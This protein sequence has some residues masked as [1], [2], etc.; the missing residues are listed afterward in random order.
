MLFFKW[1]KGYV[2][3]NIPL[4]VVV[5]LSISNITQTDCNEISLKDL[6]CNNEEL[7]K[8]KGPPYCP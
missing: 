3:G 2:F 6:R 1:Q 5:G 4:F 8:L 7:I